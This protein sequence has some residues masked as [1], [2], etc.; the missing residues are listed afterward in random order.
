M[1]GTISATSE[2]VG[3]GSTFTVVLP[4]TIS[5]PDETPTTPER[6][7]TPILTTSI[8]ATSAAEEQPPP[9]AVA[10][11]A[12]RGKAKGRRATGLRAHNYAADKHVGAPATLRRERNA[13]IAASPPTSEVDVRPTA[14][15]TLALLPPT[16]SATLP[17]T[18]PAV[19]LPPEACEP[20]NGK[21]ASE[22]SRESDSIQHSKLES[23]DTPNVA[24]PSRPRSHSHHKHHAHHL[25]NHRHPRVPAKEGDPGPILVVDD[26][27]VNRKVGS[28]R[29]A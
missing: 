11:V 22:S 29:P 26:D 21:S 1:G 16:P 14:G 13:G 20:S 18:P 15:I 6:A 7:L 2:G 12:S 3:R 8:A 27:F 25:H 17:P 10:L 5:N 4:I 28:T 9:G 19:L 24:I 23:F